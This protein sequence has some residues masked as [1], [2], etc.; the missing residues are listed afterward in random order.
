M[1]SIVPG[2][3]SST[4]ERVCEYVSLN[5]TTPESPR[6]CSVTFAHLVLGFGSGCFKSLTD[7]SANVSFTAEA[8]G[9]IAVGE[10]AEVA[11]GFPPSDSEP[12]PIA[13]SNPRLGSTGSM[14]GTQGFKVCLVEPGDR[15]ST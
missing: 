10:A 6:N 8:E 12:S 5:H 14:M 13:R 2:N 11:D 4:L 9:D 7:G 15:R 3:A 1:S